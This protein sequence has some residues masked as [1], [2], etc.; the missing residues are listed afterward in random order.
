[1]RSSSS[2]GQFGDKLIPKI[3][4]AVVQ[5]HIATKKGLA[6]TEH[7]LRTRIAKSVADV[8]GEELAEV[9]Q[10]LV[11]EV[12]K[13]SKLPD[14]IQKILKD[15]A[16]GEQQ[17]KA[18]AGMLLGYSGVP[19]VLGSVMNNEFAPV[20][21]RLLS[22]NPLI[23]P[24]WQ[25][26]IS[27]VNRGQQDLET[28]RGQ[29]AGQGINADW[30]DALLALD[31]SIPDVATLHEWLRRSLM[32][33]TDARGW[34]TR[35]G[36]PGSVQNLYIDLV[37]ELLSPADAALA[38]LRGDA[39]Q[40]Y[41]YEIAN[42]AGL[43]NADFDILVAN[44][45][46]PPGLEQLLEAYRRK[47]ID[48]AT[49]EKGIRQS[50]VRDEW[51]PT[52]EQLRYAPLSV[53]DAI[54]AYIQGYIT[55]AQLKNYAEQN[56]LEP[57]DLQPAVLAAGEPLSRTE[58]MDL[59]RRGFV[60]ENDVKNAI[61][62]S[63]V[64]DSYVDWAVLLKDQPMSTA[65]AIESYVQGYLTYNDMKAIA[66]QNGLREQDIE[67]LS[68]TAGDPLSKT[69]MLRLLNRGLVTEDQ[70]KD[71]LRQ[72]RLKDS[73]IDMAVEL[74][75]TLPALYE[76]RMLLTDGAITATQG[77]KLLLESGYAP[78][79][80][81]SIVTSLTGGTVTATKTLTEGML[82]QLYMEGELSAEEYTKELVAIGYT[83]TA[84]EEI[85]T[86]NDW[87]LAISQRNAVISKIRSQYI[88]R[89]ITQQ[90]ASAD[91]DAL[92]ISATMRDRLFDDW[93]IEAST[94]VRQL[95]PA[96][97]VDAWQLNLLEPNDDAANTQLALDYLVSLGYSSTDAIRLLEIKIKGQL[98]G[99]NGTSAVSSK[100][101]SGSKG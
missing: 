53:A 85:E 84:A 86:L 76:V 61:K 12:L 26:I 9:M 62:Q 46:E 91:L 23:D 10:P 45:G 78:D 33:E 49:L 32:S 55:D 29:V 75:T 80:V 31:Q 57:T 70:V 17:Y 3:V 1:M 35:N 36:I 97:I 38:I 87:K 51:I 101:G 77:T 74:R 60:T 14:H 11:S 68:L 20:V 100:E 83:Q 6:D 98:G 54:Q 93:N 48:K 22:A 40:K 96:Q 18:V 5:G 28:A 89:K 92:Q 72:S 50:R 63:R 43:T 67:P 27:M 66:E 65:D 99:T 37:R 19:G 42:A 13:T 47:F 4:A 59:W 58:M 15:T 39:T 64:K 25:N 95:T 69:E 71:A 88:S 94:V 79:I 73:Y 90:Q 44:T 7:E 81:K 41:G 21:R 52:V 24:P 16:S 56:G 8:I 2:S 82:T 30:I 34:L